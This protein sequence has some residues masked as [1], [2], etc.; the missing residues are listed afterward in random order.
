MAALPQ[1]NTA[2]FFLDYS[3]G[4]NEHS[5]TFRISNT[6]TLVTIK[7]QVDTFLDQLSGILFTITILG[8]RVAV[9]GSNVTNPTP[10]TG[11]TTYGTLSMPAE[12]APQELRFIGRSTDGRRVSVSMYG[13]DGAIPPTYR[14]T[15]ASNPVIEAAILALSNASALGVGLTITG[16]LPVWK[17]YASFNFNSYWE[18]EARP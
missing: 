1:S 14:I 7:S 15:S 9:S 16:Q 3:D 11:N 10:W 2:R 8:C 4:V 18:K 12:F 6:A 17:A 5:A 13:F